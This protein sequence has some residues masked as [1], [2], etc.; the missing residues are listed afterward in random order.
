MLVALAAQQ[1][2]PLLGRVCPAAT[3]LFEAAGAGLAVMNNGEFGSMWMHGSAAEVG[4]DLQMML[5]EGPGRDAFV[6]GSLIEEGH[7]SSSTRWV[8]FSRRMSDS[9][10]E[11]V[12]S[13]PLRLGAAT[14]GALTVYRDSPDVFS[15][16]ETADGY[17]LADVAAYLIL[18]AQAAVTTDAMITEMEGGFARLVPI[19]QATGILMVQLGVDVNEA[20]VRLR[21][22][23]FVDGV[24]L[25]TLAGLVVSHEV[26]FTLDH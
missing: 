23:A 6:T 15:G 14:F 16:P 2:G 9:G 4:E 18:G 8:A 26:E 13:F 25:L 7:L 19:H 10:V 5:G 24:A 11:S 1:G 21:A 17:V 3:T 12:A 20:L 22:R